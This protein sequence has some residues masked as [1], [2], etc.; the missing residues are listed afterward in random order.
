MKRGIRSRSKAVKI[1]GPQLAS[2]ANTSDVAFSDSVEHTFRRASRLIYS[3]LAALYTDCFL[4]QAPKTLT[5]LMI[6]GH[7]T[8]FSHTDT[9][10][11]PKQRGVSRWRFPKTRLCTT[12]VPR[13][14]YC[15]KIDG[16]NVMSA[17]SVLVRP[18]NRPSSN[19]AKGAKAG[20][21]QFRVQH[22]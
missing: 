12:V 18:N 14:Q 5:S 11:F 6:S 15:L 9:R 13:Y 19:E 16:A 21:R 22:V 17:S 20:L 10:F 1:H 8:T 4:K 7:T 2:T 3:Y